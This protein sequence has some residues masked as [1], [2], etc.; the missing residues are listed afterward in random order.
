MK[1]VMHNKK[2]GYQRKMKN[3]ELMSAYTNINANQY[4]R[5]RLVR[6]GILP[7]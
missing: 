3:S 2:K 7:F 1:K 4:D 5:E 6:F